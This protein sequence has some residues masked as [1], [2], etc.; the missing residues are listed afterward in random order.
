MLQVLVEYDDV[1][2]QRREWLS[3]HRDAV[4]SFFLIEKGLCWAERPDPRHTSLIAIDHHNH[5]NN[6]HHLR[7]NGKSL[8]GTTAAANTVA[9]PAIVSIFLVTIYLNDKINF[10]LR[11]LQVRKTCFY[12]WLFMRIDIFN[13]NRCFLIQ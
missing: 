9:W 1:E 11:S 3:P 10:N 2:W 8:R 7:I 5:S 12:K 6:N 4:F 13:Q